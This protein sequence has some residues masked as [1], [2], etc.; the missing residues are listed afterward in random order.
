MPRTGRSQALTA[1]APHAA[2]PS[3]GWRLLLAAARRLQRGRLEVQFPDRQRF[4]FAGAAPGPDAT[5]VVRDPAFIR[6]VL[7]G[8]DVAFGEAYVDGAWD[9]PSLVDLLEL[10][11]LNRGAFAGIAGGSWLGRAAGWLRHALNRNSRAGSRRNI[12]AH[13]DLGNAFYEL[14]LDHET[15]AY[16][17]AH[18]DRPDEDLASAQRNKFRELLARLDLR[19]EHHLLEIGSGWGGFALHAA[20]ETGCRVT[21]ITLSVEQLAEARA[22]ARAA[23]LADRVRFELVDYR[24]AQGTFDRI[25]SIEMFEAVGERYWPAFFRA[26]HDRLAPGGRAALQVITIDEA[27]FEG[28]R[29]NPD[30]IQKHVFPGGMLPSPECFAAAARAAGLAVEAPSFHG[31]DYARTLAHW[32]RR[33]FAARPEIIARGY[34]A[35]FL[36]LWHYYLAYCEAGF[37]T[38]HCDLMRVALAK[39][40]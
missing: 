30:F 6:R 21:S 28:Y 36:R 19:P 22:R 37:R 20:R 9:T 25:A 4:S 33:V 3:L 7:V 5:L 12:A 26:V 15:M 34:D 10:L 31:A 17:A 18:F 11:D 8:G 13:Y 40:A 23:G 35:R 27:F 32:D 39:P 16:S 14:W 2:S 1:G 29:R 38:G 24:D